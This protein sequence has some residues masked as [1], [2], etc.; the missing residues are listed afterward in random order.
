MAAVD[1]QER[2]LMIGLT[3]GN[4]MRWSAGSTGRRGDRATER[5]SGGAAERQSLVEW[6]GESAQAP[7]GLLQVPLRSIPCGDCCAAFHIPFAFAVPATK[8]TPLEP[9]NKL[10][11]LRMMFFGKPSAQ[12]PHCGLPSRFACPLR[13]RKLE[14]GQ[15]ITPAASRLSCFLAFP[16]NGRALARKGYGHFVRGRRNGTEG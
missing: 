4:Q 11:M 7:T 5:R 16:V 14:E 1:V 9:K 3:I 6:M 13:L 2:R 8:G 10:V 15:G 12:C